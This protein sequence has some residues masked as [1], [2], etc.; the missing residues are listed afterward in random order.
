MYPSHQ[1]VYNPIKCIRQTVEIREDAVFVLN[2][3]Q[4]ILSRTHNVIFY[5]RFYGSR[6]AHKINAYRC[7]SLETSFA[8][9]KGRRT[10]Q[11]HVIQGLYETSI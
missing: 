11:R 1:F 6:T 2:R 4:W 5:G 3:F 9:W 8:V 7:E 10:T